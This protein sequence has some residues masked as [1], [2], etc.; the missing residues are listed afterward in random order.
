ML[1]L[2]PCD[3]EK[4]EYVEWETYDPKYWDEDKQM[5]M[6]SE[7]GLP[8]CDHEWKSTYSQYTYNAHICEKCGE[9]DY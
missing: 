2:E 8:W 5:W 4:F 9:R 6:D 3:P 1:S 7:T